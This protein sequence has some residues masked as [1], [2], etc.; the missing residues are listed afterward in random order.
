MAEMITHSFR[1]KKAPKLLKNSHKT[2][3]IPTAPKNTGCALPLL[4]WHFL[5]CI[6][7]LMLNSNVKGRLLRAAAKK[8][9]TWLQA[10]DSANHQEQSS[11]WR[12]DYR[13]LRSCRER[14]SASIPRPLTYKNYKII[15]ACSLKLLHLWSLWAIEN[16]YNY[17]FYKM[18]HNH[19]LNGQVCIL[20]WDL[21]HKVII[22]LHFLT[23]AYYSIRCLALYL[24]LCSCCPPPQVFPAP[25]DTSVW[26]PGTIKH[27]P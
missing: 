12:C 7:A 16:Y 24:C 18:L 22:C 23:Y 10:L 4:L 1:P 11:P 26:Y 2:L 14:P 5:L 8:L 6:S 13:P 25:K 21:T 19:T 20:L 17:S 3:L 9:D 15:S 27:V